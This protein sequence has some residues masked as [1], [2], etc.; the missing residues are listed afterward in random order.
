MMMKNIF[1][2]FYT[3]A[4]WLVC[5]VAFLGHF[6]LALIVPWFFKDPQAVNQKMTAPFIRTGYFLLGIR[7]KVSGLAHLPKGPFVLVSNH[8]SHLDII[9][10]LASVGRKISFFA[11]KELLRVPILG[12]DIQMQGHFVVDRKNALVASKQLE[13]VRKKVEKGNA[14]FFFPE[15]TRS[16][17][18]SIGKFKRGAF[19]L[20]VQAGVPIVPCYL[21]G[22]NSILNKRRK[23]ARP[24]TI[25][26]T[27]GKPIAV[28]KESEKEKINAQAQRLMEESRD[29]IL[30]LREKEIG[31]PASGEN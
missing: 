29:I 30:K 31:I 14:V 17:D 7:L 27:I 28:K 21:N 20:A 4:L 3:I 2:F 1:Y 19:V 23:L 18:Q 9:S 5:F 25:T 8:Q 12:W 26:I 24:G 15:G 16:V 13:E 6:L 11:K 22:T 10:I